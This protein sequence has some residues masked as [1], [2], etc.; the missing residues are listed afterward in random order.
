MKLTY[1][2]GW[3]VWHVVGALL[4]TAAGVWVTRD[5]W[6]EILLI[7]TRDEEASHILLVPIVAAWMFWV[8]RARVRQCRPRDQWVGPAMVAAGWAIMSYG[9]ANAHMALWHG[10]G[11]LVVLGCFCTVMGADV[12]LKFLP[13]V[14]VLGFLIPIPG[15]IR[16]KIAIPLATAMAQSAEFVFS[17]VMDLP[18]TRSGNQVQINGEPINIAEACNGLRMVFALF[19]VS[20]AFAFGTPFRWYVR[21]VILAASPLLAIACNLVRLV[22]T[23]YLY[24]S[25]RESMALAF[26]DMAGWVMILVAFLLLLGVVQLL[27]WAQLEISPYSLARG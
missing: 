18:V 2:N 22:P 15:I 14:I 9:H 24:G 4:L 13:A 3:T 20:Y 6:W 7:A 12:L 11:L 19:L 21:A 27:R 23:I 1:R 26:H 5:V 17:G 10:G 25:A 8:R 16:A